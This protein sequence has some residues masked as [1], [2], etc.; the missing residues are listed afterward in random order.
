MADPRK[1]EATNRAQKLVGLL[2]AIS[3][4]ITTGQLSPTSGAALYASKGQGLH[5][6]LGASLGEASVPTWRV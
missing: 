1:Y 6:R 2:F 4:Q 3:D 5:Y